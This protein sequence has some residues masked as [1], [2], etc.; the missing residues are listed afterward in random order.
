MLKSVANAWYKL[1]FKPENFFIK[2]GIFLVFHTYNYR[3]NFIFEL[4]TRFP[5]GNVYNF[6]DNFFLYFLSTFFPDEFS[7]TCGNVSKPLIL[8]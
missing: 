8:A 2:C 4:S 5:C 1:I 7:Q 3:L 6:V